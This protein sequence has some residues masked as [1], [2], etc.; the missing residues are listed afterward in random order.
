M[1]AVAREGV[2]AVENEVSDRRVSSASEN[3]QASDT[4]EIL[5]RAVEPAQGVRTLKVRLPPIFVILP[6]MSLI[7]N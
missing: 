3:M 4:L 1:R 5:T 7:D 6:G 2:T